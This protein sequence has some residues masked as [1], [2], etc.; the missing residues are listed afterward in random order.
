L[1]LAFILALALALDLS[2][3]WLFTGVNFIKIRPI[4][5]SIYRRSMY[6]RVDISLVDVLEV[7]ILSVDVLG[8]DLSLV[9]ILRLSHTYVVKKR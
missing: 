5:W 3:F 1:I 7:D 2:N 9:D 4:N 8:V 6:L